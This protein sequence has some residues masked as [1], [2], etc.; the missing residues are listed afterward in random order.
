MPLMDHFRPPLR[1]RFPYTALHSAWA[2]FLATNLVERWLPPTFTAL[3]H[4]YQ[5]T[6][7]EIDVAAYETSGGVVAQGNGAV[8]TLPRTWTAPPPRATA[9]FEFP[10]NFEVL[11]YQDEEGMQLVGAIE[12]VSPKNK[13]RPDRRHSFVRKCASPL[14]RGVSVVILDVVTERR[15]NLHNQLMRALEIEGAALLGAGVGIYASSY[16]PVQRDDRIEV[17][18]WA[19]PCVTGQPVPTMPLRLTGDLIVPVEF[20]EA[21][22][23]ICRRRKLT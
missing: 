10:D 11:V 23:E 1:S 4:T 13:D 2:A 17:D 6:E 14:Q 8:A 12:F 20:E 5:G 15:A 16:R 18:L 9:P 7:I 19:E 3:E 21:Y 22:L